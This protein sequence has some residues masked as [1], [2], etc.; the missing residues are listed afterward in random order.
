[1]DSIQILKEREVTE[2]PLLL[3]DCELSSGWVD[4]WSTHKVNYQGNVYEPRVLRHNLF[5]IKAASDDGIDG[6]S[7]AVISLAN[8][9][10][11]FSQIER[12]TGWKAS[13][14]TVR[15][16]FYDLKAG[17]AA[18]D[19]ATLFYGI[20]NPPEEV[21]ETTF[22]LSFG[23]R[24]SLQ[25]VALPT[26]RIQKRCPWTFPATVHE[27]TEAFD[28][29]SRGVYSPFFACG[30][31]ADI[32]G[33]VGN[34][35]G[36]N[37]FT[38]CN[39]TRQDCEQR[40]M[41]SKDSRGNPTARF[42]GIGFV[43]TTT[44]VR[45][46]GEKQSHASAM[47]DNQARYNDVV[48]LVY[49][50]GWY[51]PP[52]VF[53][54]NDGN[55]TRMEILLGLGPIEGVLKVIVNDVEIPLARTGTNMTA[56]G[57]Y[58]LVTSGWSIGGFNLDFTDGTGN[59]LGEPHGSMAVLSVVVP[60]RVSEAKSRPRVQ[61]LLQG[62]KLPT[63]TLDGEEIGSVF[64]NNPAWV[65]LDILR[66]TGWGVSEL[67]L[68]SFAEAATFCDLPADIADP[69]GNIHTDRQFQCNLVL[70]S[71]RSAADL[72]RGVRVGSGLYLTSGLN[73]KLK[74]AVEG[75]FAQQT[76]T[77]PAGSNSISTFNGGWPGYEFGDGTDGF[78]GILRRDNGSPS[79]RMWSRSTADSPNRYSIEFQ[80]ALNEYQ[81]DSLSLVDVDDAVSVGQ[82]VAGN[83]SC[84]GIPNFTQA[85]RIIR[86]YLNKSLHGNV[87][88]EFDTTVK[89]VTLR[90]GDLITLTYL[91]EGLIRQSFRV[92]KIAPSSDYVQATITAQLHDDTWYVPSNDV[93]PGGRRQPGSEL[94][95]P[96]PLVGTVADA[97]QGSR[98]DIKEEV[99]QATDDTMRIRLA[100]E[101]AV[102][103]QPA[104]SKT[105]IPLI[106]LLPYIENTGGTL[107]G[108]QSIY[109]AVSGIDPDGSEGP[110]SFIVRAVIP[111]GTDTNKVTLT[112]VSV[113][114]KTLALNLYR[115]LH[116]GQL[117]RVAHEMPVGTS[118]SD[119]GLSSELV[120]P[121]D[122]NF[123]HANFYW[124]MELQPEVAVNLFGPNQ[125]GNDTLGM[126]P[127]EFR[128][129][130]LRITT[131]KG[132]GQE[133]SIITNDSTLL[134][135][136]PA[137]TIVPDATSRFL[138]C[139]S[140]WNFGCVASSSPAVF[141]VPN[142][143]GITLHVLGRSANVHDRESAIELAPLTRHVIGG[144][145]AR[146]DAD[147]P[148]APT[149]GLYAPGDG[150]VDLI[151]V[152]FQ[153]LLN[154]HSIAAGT[155]VLHYWNELSDPPSVE[156]GTG[157]DALQPELHLSTATSVAPGDLLQ[158]DNEVFRITT[159]LDANL[160]VE[161]ERG[162][163]GSTAD[164]HQ[165]GS[166]V[167]TLERRVFI[168]PFPKGFF[169]SPASGSYSF[170]VAA[171]DIRIA[172]AEF[173]VTNSRGS[174]QVMEKCFTN[175]IEG[176]LRTLPGGQYS[177]QVEGPLAIQTDAAPPMVV[178]TSHS[179]RDIFAVLREPAQSGT[180][181]LQL[182]QAAQ[183]YGTLTIP[184]GD[185]QSNVI[186]GFGL[187]PLREGV[188]MA[189]DI[190]SVGQLDTSPGRDLTVIIRL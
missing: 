51:N 169:G 183:V 165:A 43:P 116:P 37:P 11:H 103:A 120:G 164:I 45:S 112:N 99:I 97:D 79:I 153:N 95:M 128:G 117:L 115:G 190:L 24:L 181:D 100:A 105:G 14:L 182:R 157:V 72:V 63:Y 48:P 25:R 35:D 80:D 90:P 38:T 119:D 57:W 148:E 171:N 17:A 34:L 146:G 154:T 137:W 149:F 163:F 9:D 113:D 132:K 111:Q 83:L 172:T 8:S 78:S 179:V 168:A 41:F 1:M 6:I 32:T 106:G 124:R 3:F 108:D 55:L 118:I 177:I 125:A 176:G 62:M 88:V 189:L 93:D 110:L 73:G 107:V 67:D 130:T 96:R 188:P 175:T 30:Y 50:T 47:V 85:A 147:V 69:N 166:K 12:A 91:K 40:G 75:T 122:A 159:N 74:L 2:T 84:L 160:R 98:F 129:K 68:A 20:A 44:L 134:T 54:K 109:Y 27:R 174:S 127:N 180:I 139:E 76:P 53:A 82:E 155:L 173:S 10:S 138:V 131:G 156:L 89:G 31:S 56:T 185:T 52:I 77:K 186:N 101:F 33:G 13:K 162:A 144:A 18:S 58:N 26:V 71:R 114:S 86:R 126:L 170:S 7:R 42:G 187:T 16:L 59:P 152:G 158:V 29:G 21:T 64:T 70:R 19:A 22:R 5:E 136:A 102:P 66:R 92:W 65:L 81:Q 133:R 135:V 123:D 178:E 28:G 15:F 60:N 121:P 61:V 184:T 4:R 46:Y 142:V 39:Y 140:S 150:R 161:V 143:Q 36:T 141:E 49:G 167:Y 94:G 23:N 145:T 151:G 87:Y 104:A